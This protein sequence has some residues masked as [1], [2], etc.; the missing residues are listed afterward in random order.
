MCC[1][2]LAA[3]MRRS[4]GVL[5]PL[6]A[7]VLAPLGAG[8]LAPLALWACFLL[9]ARACKTIWKFSAPTR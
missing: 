5:A 2:G 8:V 9:P 7:G 6:G 1:G 4:A 3:E